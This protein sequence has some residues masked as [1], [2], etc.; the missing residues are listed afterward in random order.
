MMKSILVKPMIAALFAA[1]LF[2]VS[3]FVFASI[4]PI[5]NENGL[6][7][8]PF[9]ATGTDL[10]Y[11]ITSAESF[12]D[13]GFFEVLMRYV[14]YYLTFDE[15]ILEY[16]YVG[17]LFPL[18]IYFTDYRPGNTIGL[19][20]VFL[21]MSTFLCGLW[22]GWL[23][24]FKI[25]T[26][27]LFLFAVLPAPVWFTLSLGTDLPFAL[28]FATFFIS[29]FNENWKSKHICIWLC[30]VFLMA[31]TR[32]NALSIL[33]FVCID[34]A[35]RFYKTRHLSDLAVMSASVVLCVL[36]SVFYLPYFLKFISSDGSLD[37]FGILPDQYYVGVFSELSDWL[38]KPL[39]WFLL[40]SSKLLYLVGLR[41]S[42]AG[43][44]EFVVVLRALPGLILLPGLVWLFA[45]GPNRL[46]LLMVTFLAPILLGASQERYIL[47]IVPIL[48]AYG[49]QSILLL[50]KF[51]NPRT[52][53]R[54][55]GE[56]MPT[57]LRQAFTSAF[58]AP[59]PP[60]RRPE[61]T[62]AWPDPQQ[63]PTARGTVVNPVDH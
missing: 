54:A 11:Y 46:R 1:I 38:N 63:N 29:Y 41:P 18:L 43:V 39:S 13:L 34:T 58:A 36:G 50:A 2:R 60:S 20:L 33:L 6:P 22:L 37:Y 12:A 45:C 19:S 35:W 59:R 32:P 8:S 56:D 51:V 24:K 26:G 27:W 30:C 9:R 28:F 3:V 5:K 52:G 48:F 42:Y 10:S 53:T 62:S 14:E 16:I 7:V 61:Q 31:M 47:P 55:V 21:A 15:I 49:V 25:G 23:N 57:A 4:W 40:G 44:S 17:P